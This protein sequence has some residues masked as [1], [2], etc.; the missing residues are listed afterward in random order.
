[1]APASLN[2]L[3]ADLRAALNA[4]AEKHRRELPAHLP[5]EIRVGTRAVSVADVARKQLLSDDEVRRVVDAA[6]EVGEDFGRFIMLAAATG[7]RFSQLAAVTV[8]DVQPAQRRVMV[9]GSRKGRA[10][11]PHAP[12]AVPIAEDVL[13]RLEP[14]LLARDA[15]EPLLLRWH[16]RRLGPWRRFGEQRAGFKWEKTHRG[17]WVSANDL[18]RPWAAAVERAAVPSETIPYALRHSSIVRGLRAGLPVRLVAALHDTSTEM[19][20]RHYAAFIVDATE[21]LARRASLSLGAST[22]EKIAA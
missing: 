20:E 10:A 21:E 8:G 9:P 17:P 12:V 22:A 1:M 11:R 6:F 13:E 19:I 3:L 18:D 2:R 15:R 5:G 7:A 14:A 16:Y 4:T